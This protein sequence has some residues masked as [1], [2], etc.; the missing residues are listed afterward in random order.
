MQ[1]DV[2]LFVSFSGKSPELLNVLSHVS[3]NTR[4]IAMTSHVDPAGCPLL[5]E[6]ED[7]IL[8]PAPTPEKEEESLGVAAPTISTTVA[9]AVADM[10]ALTV[11]DQLHGARTRE[12][13]KRNHPGGAIGM[14]HRALD[15]LK[16]KS[17]D[18]SVAGLLSPS[19][20]GSDDG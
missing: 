16:R 17:E 19:A 14:N 8:L 7:S 6:H 20:S 1:N 12:V 11:A 15:K 9:L 13:F 5:A 18:I 3:E 2:L 10:L 4:V